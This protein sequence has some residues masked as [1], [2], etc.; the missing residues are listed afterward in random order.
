VPP[1]YYAH[2][3][4]QQYDNNPPRAQSNSVPLQGYGAPP[5]VY[6]PRVDAQEYRERSPA[7]DSYVY[8]Q[9]R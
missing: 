3:A 2:L 7:P 6:Y 5:A 1:D 8:Y 9:D 4:R